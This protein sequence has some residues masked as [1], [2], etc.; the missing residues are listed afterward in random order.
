MVQHRTALTT[1]P[2]ILQ[3]VIIA[4]RLSI[5]RRWQPATGGSKCLVCVLFNYWL[6]A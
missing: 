4:Q 3:T 5:K 1:F 6:V 2:L